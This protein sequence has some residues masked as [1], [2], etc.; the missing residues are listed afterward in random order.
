M[1]VN[2]D[3]LPPAPLVVRWTVLRA[4]AA[5]V[6]T[7]VSAISCSRQMV[8]AELG[9]GGN[10]GDRATGVGG[11]PIETTGTNGPAVTIGTAAAGGA[12]TSGTTGIGGSGGIGGFAGA[13]GNSSTDGGDTDCSG[14]PCICMSSVR[15]MDG[16]L[17]RDDCAGDLLGFT[18]TPIA[19]IPNQPNPLREQ[20]WQ[21]DGPCITNDQPYVVG[22]H[23]YG[24]VECKAYAGN[25]T[26]ANPTE[27]A[28]PSAVHNLWIE[29]GSEVRNRWTTY[30]LTVTALPSTVIPG[31]DVMPDG[32]V[33]FLNQCP[34][35]EMPNVTTWKI[36][37]TVN[38]VVPGGGFINYVE[39]DD[40]CN[41]NANCGDLPV[42]AQCINRHVVEIPATASPPPPSSFVQP[43]E[44]AF[45][46][47]GQWWFVDVTSINPL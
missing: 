1:R 5:W 23:I 26:R 24:V 42:L 45:R 17:N 28:D 41:M 47:P 21:L 15:L 25:F 2:V 18:C 7:I 16:Y 35:G 6:L 30:A 33:Y 12:T 3:D 13:G 39:Y 40:D 4:A 9:V 27:S 14:D 29:G 37:Y 43:I 32:Q 20:H 11:G 44:N 36:D 46:A 8:F 34:P 38:L 10:G 22:L 31:R 19:C